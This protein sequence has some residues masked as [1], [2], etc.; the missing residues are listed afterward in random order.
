V[1]RVLNADVDYE[2]RKD[3][4]YAEL[5][6]N[7][8]SWRL[9]RLL[10]HGTIGDINFTVVE[11]VPG[12]S[13]DIV[14][15]E[16][17]GRQREQALASYADAATLISK[18]TVTRPWFGELLYDP[19]YRRASWADYL[20][21]RATAHAER[22]GEVFAR[23]VPHLASVLGAFRDR[24]RELSVVQPELVHGDYFPGNVMVDDDLRVT[25][26]LD[27]GWSTV[28]GDPQLDLVCAGTFLE[29]DRTWCTQAD[30]D[31]VAQYLDD[32]CPGL[33]DVR[34]IYRTY[35]AL[36]FSF[37]HNYGLPLYDWCVRQLT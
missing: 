12:R 29:V 18:T 34:S 5:I 19:T 22:A 16:L 25:G 21:L 6:E 14:L 15:A 24:V 26:V 3:E 23:D 8:L 20:V 27:F 35:S 13:L 30:A 1:L 17:R 7:G 2:L 28:M 37:V 10:D 9:P 32:A 4:L 33:A 31:F 36:H 11:R